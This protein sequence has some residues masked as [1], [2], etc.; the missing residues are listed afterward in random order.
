M[1][2][3][4]LAE[5]NDDIANL[6]VRAL[7]LRDHAVVHVADGRRALERCRRDHFDILIF[8]IAMPHLSGLEVAD[9]L[10]VEGLLRWSP[11]IFL[12]A[13]PAERYAALGHAIG[14]RVYVTKPFRLAKLVDTV[15][16]LLGSRVQNPGTATGAIEQPRTIETFFA[17][18]KW[19]N[20]FVDG[21]AIDGVHDTRRGAS[22][23]AAMLARDLNVL[24]EVVYTAPGAAD[25]RLAHGHRA[26]PVPST[27]GQD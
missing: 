2:R 24:H 20:R 1:A 6:V 23:V 26:T 8:D 25:K 17:D 4:L 21:R 13:Q 22:R 5:D 19:R 16:E 18:G 15:E 11:L 10:R 27:V 9:Q 14:A 7:E 3:V 12:T